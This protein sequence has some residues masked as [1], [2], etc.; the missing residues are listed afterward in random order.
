MKLKNKE[1]KKSHVSEILKN[2]IRVFVKNVFPLKKHAKIM[3]GFSGGPDSVALLHVLKSLEKEA[4][5]TC[6]AV[7]LNHLLRGKESQRDEV[8]VKTFCARYHI[9]AFFY[10]LDV[11]RHALE[12]KANL[13]ETSRKAR[14]DFFRKT[15]KKIKTRVVF[16]AHHADDQLETI[17]MCLFR[18]CGLDGASG[19][20]ELSYQKE[21]IIAR[22]FLKIK[23]ETLLIYNKENKLRFIKDSSNNDLSF[24]RNKWR[25]KV[26]PFLQKELGPFSERILDFADI[27]RDFYEFVEQKEKRLFKEYFTYHHEK[28]KIADEAR[29]VFPFYVFAF[30]VRKAIE[31]V[32]PGSP[33]PRKQVME[34]KL[35]ALTGL[36]PG[37]V[38]EINKEILFLKERGSVYILRKDDLLLEKEMHV[39]FSGT[40]GK[41]A[42]F[43]HWILTGRK[44]KLIKTNF[45]NDIKEKKAFLKAII[46]GKRAK[47]KI[48]LRPNKIKENIIVRSFQKGDRIL[49]MQKKE[50]HTKKV[51]DLFIDAKIPVF[52]KKKIP[53]F[54]SSKKI[55]CI[56]G[57]YVHPEYKVRSGDKEVLCLKIKVT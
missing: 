30:A 48:L 16:T 25:L 8:F 5:F 37:K 17:F 42:H 33:V 21:L 50:E 54:I 29:N 28:V 35:K 26:I 1:I 43:F 49:F 41:D 10:K 4:G 31:K 38:L 7:H 14:M 45:R 19:M 52:L 6:H 34:K 39:W 22:P 55:I 44:K 47:R 12:E 56:P 51:K 9:P 57:L 27:S 46:A 32:F 24:A 36:Q 23:K 18:G 13:E 3:V 2:R 11:K 20:K 40:K 53:L 15:G